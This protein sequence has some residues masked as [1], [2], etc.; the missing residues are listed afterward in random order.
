[1]VD[2]TMSA[3][4]KCTAQTKRL[5]R[6]GETRR[7]ACSHTHIT[8]ARALKEQNFTQAY[9][10][11]KTD[12]FRVRTGAAHAHLQYDRTSHPD[13]DNLRLRLRMPTRKET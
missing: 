6:G 13:M 9:L 5:Q 3:L 11:L 7:T 4:I 2:F 12:Q 10:K 1:M 8:L